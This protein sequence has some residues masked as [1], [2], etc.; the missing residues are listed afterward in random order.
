MEEATKAR[1]CLQAY[2]E[3]DWYG[4]IPQKNNR[5]EGSSQRF[6]RLKLVV[7]FGS[8]GV[9]P[10]RCED[11]VIDDAGRV[12]PFRI[13]WATGESGFGRLFFIVSDLSRSDH[14]VHRNNNRSLQDI[15]KD[16]TKR[17]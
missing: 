6:D 8:P 15:V 12:G 2:Q 1:I 13:E 17:R 3:A 10:H 14:G 16:S 5:V 7:D 4:T 9:F 11:A